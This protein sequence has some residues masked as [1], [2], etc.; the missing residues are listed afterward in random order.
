MPLLD[1]PLLPIARIE[2]VVRPDPG[3]DRIR[4]TVVLDLD[5][6]SLVRETAD[7]PIEVREQGERERG[8]GHQTHQERQS[9][10]VSFH[11]STTL[12]ETDPSPDH[13]YLKSY[14]HDRA[15]TMIY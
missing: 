7:C 9:H 1:K 4:D 13:E 12:I 10:L 14:S 15:S 3:V 11:R 6:R 8:N 5:I 2:V